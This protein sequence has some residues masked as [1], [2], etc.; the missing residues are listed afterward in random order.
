MMI[1]IDVI[2]IDKQQR[3]V[4]LCPNVTSGK[5]SVTCRGAH[6]IIELGSGAIAEIDIKDGDKLEII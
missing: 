2:F 6:S 1:P 4:K 5:W 3:V